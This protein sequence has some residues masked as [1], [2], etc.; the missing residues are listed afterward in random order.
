V[1]CC[2]GLP[3]LS[4]ALVFLPC[5][6][7]VRVVMDCWYKVEFCVLG[8]KVFNQSK[9]D[10]GFIFSPRLDSPKGFNKVPNV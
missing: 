6:W 3:S 5:D 7:I 10:C 8:L 2:V 1:S 4:T 9:A